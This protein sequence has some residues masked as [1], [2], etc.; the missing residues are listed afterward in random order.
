V[1]S[2]LAERHGVVF[3]ISPPPDERLAFHENPAAWRLVTSTPA[4]IRVPS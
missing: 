1:R 4:A 3:V 2:A